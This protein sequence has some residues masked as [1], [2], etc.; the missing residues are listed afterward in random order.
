MEVISVRIP[1]QPRQLFRTSCRLRVNRIIGELIMDKNQNELFEE[2]IDILLEGYFEVVFKERKNKKSRKRPT[3]DL[4]VR[5]ND[6]KVVGETFS[7]IYRR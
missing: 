4:R 2:I 1:Y 6:D 5:N 7:N 3:I